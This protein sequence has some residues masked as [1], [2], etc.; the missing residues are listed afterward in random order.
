MTTSQADAARGDTR[1]HHFTQQ[2][3]ALSAVSANTFKEAVRNKVF[4]TLLF[5][6]G[7]LILSSMVLGEMSLHHELRTAKSMTMFASSLFGM[8]IS[9]YSS[10]TLLH[11]EFERRTIYTILSKPIY[12]W[13]FLLGKYVGVMGLVFVVMALMCATTALVIKLQGGA[14]E[15]NLLVGFG[16]LYLQMM[17][18]TALAHLFATFASPLLSGF[19]TVALFVG[20]N[21]FNQ[22]QL[23]QRLL[24]EQHRPLLARLVGGLELVLPNLQSLNLSDEI[25]YGLAIPAGYTLSALW[26]AS[27]YTLVV[28]L[29]GM[30]IFTWRDLN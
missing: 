17:I 8:I 26:Y 10:I 18:V 2:L 23:I 28:L 13:Q 22:L 5:F 27:S 25:T 16:A 30:F 11:T 1:D 9:V 3:R 24:E 6:A 19:A 12:R 7:L 20:G 21:L 15:L 4:G 29:L 14:L